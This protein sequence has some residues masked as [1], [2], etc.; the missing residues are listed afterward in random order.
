VGLL[1]GAA[2]ASGVLA[3]AIL[4]LATHLRHRA[5][6]GIM[7]LGAGVLLAVASIEIASEALMLAG[8]AS[9]VGGIVAGAATFSIANEALVIAATSAPPQ[10]IVRNPRLLLHQGASLAP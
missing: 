1:L 10:A 7:S 3:G 5:I 4:G 9:T 2:A 6:A 8:A